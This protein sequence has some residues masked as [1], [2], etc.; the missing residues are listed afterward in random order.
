MIGLKGVPGKEKAI[1]EIAITSHYFRLAFPDEDGF[2]SGLETT[3]VYD[4]PLTTMPAEDRS[5]LGIFYPIMGHMAHFAVV[6]VDP[7][8]GKVSFLDYVAVHDA[9]TVVNPKTLAGH[10]RG[11]ERRW[12]SERRCTRPSISMRTGSC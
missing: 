9:G 11:G 3:A 8:T 2:E 7:E 4:H 6:G 12:V 1:A 10:I 5:H